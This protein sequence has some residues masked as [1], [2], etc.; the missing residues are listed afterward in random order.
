MPTAFVATWGTGRPVIGIMAELD[1]LPGLSQRAVCHKEPVKEGAPGHG[2]GHNVFATSGL[3][4]GIAAKRGMEENELGGTIKV[5]GCPA[6]ETLVGK[7]FMV[8][9]GCFDGLD[10]CLGNHVW[11]VNGVDFN[12][13]T[14][15]NSFKVEFYGKA[16]HAAASPEQGRSALDAVELM[17]VGVNFLREHVVQ[18][19]RIHYVVQDGGMQPNVVPPYA[20]SWYYVRAS[21]REVV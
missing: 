21:R 8:R 18:E 11:Y 16:S 10:A 15:M 17:N 6:E 4:G 7:V 20:R 2:C 19:A 3:I 5:L 13:C 12:P 1:A 9:D 14:A